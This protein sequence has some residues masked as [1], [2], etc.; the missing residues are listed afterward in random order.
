M[1]DL[2]IMMAGHISIPIYPTLGAD[3]IFQILTH[4][5]S[6]AIIIGKLD[7]YKSQK[8]GI[9]DI[10][11]ISISLYGEREGEIWED[12]LNNEYP[13]LEIHKQQPDDLATIIYTSGTTGTPKGVMHTVNNFM[14]AANTFKEAVDLPEHPRF[15]SYLP[16]GHIAERVG[17]E[18]FGLVNG[19]TISFAESLDTFA[20]DLE[21]TQ[22]H[23]FFAVPRIWSKF[24]EKILENLPQKKLDTLMRIPLLN[25]IIKKKLKKK[26][27]LSSAV[28]I[29]S[30]A[31]PLAVSLIDWYKKIGIK[32]LQGYGMTEDCI[33][34]HINLPDKN[35]TGSVGQALEGV[36]TKL[37]AE[38]ELCLHNGCL[39]Q[40]YFKN[41]EITVE[42]FTEDGYLKTG[43]IGEY[44]HDG[45]FFITGRAKD[46]FKTDKGKYISPA[47]IELELS[48]NLDIEQICIVGT[49]IPQPIALVTTSL[50]AKEK[51]RSAL[52][53]SLLASIEAINPSLDKH[54][55]IEKIIIMKED[56]T[57]ENGLATPTLKVKRNS[58]EKI[59]QPY[60]LS[61]F[62]NPDKVIFE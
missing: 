12:L 60:Y 20:A 33:I 28:T 47:P 8:A 29:I 10:H 52:S 31:A 14:V 11:K 1:S 53:E 42:V 61:W 15:F 58:I 21:A 6:K 44:D 7:D 23:T 18:M 13:P 3:S 51:S 36:K 17:I 19:A 25:T 34:S 39:M 57:V 46:Q 32:I 37:T 45:Y 62:E 30:G 38:G 5:E 50:I 43:D 22:P 55:K 9:P 41:P 40:G 59:H 16:L 26:L 49:G 24:Q 27:G 35:R 54:E 4:S 48:K 2:A 56:W